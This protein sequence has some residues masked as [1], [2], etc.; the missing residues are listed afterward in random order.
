MSHIHPIQRIQVA[1]ILFAV[2]GAATLAV[3]EP[4]TSG[5]LE[6]CAD[7]ASVPRPV[8]VASAVAQTR[9]PW[10]AHLPAVFL[11]RRGRPT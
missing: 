5:A 3:A 1:A 4:T 11:L 6:P 2:L 9:S 10:R 8:V 7:R